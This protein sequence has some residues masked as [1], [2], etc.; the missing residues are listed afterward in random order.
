MKYSK[1][2]LV[3]FEVILEVWHPLSLIV[4][5]QTLVYLLFPPLTMDIPF[6]S[7]AQILLLPLLHDLISSLLSSSH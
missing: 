2:L 5:Q 4:L 7:S 1:F 6:P 3:L